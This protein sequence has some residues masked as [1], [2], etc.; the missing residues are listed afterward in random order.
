MEE[1]QDLNLSKFNQNLMT[2]LKKYFIYLF[3]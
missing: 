2:T 1:K 3:F